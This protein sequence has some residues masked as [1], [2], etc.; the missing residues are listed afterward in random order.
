MEKRNQ[1]GARLRA[2]TQVR[3]Y[4]GFGGVGR[5]AHRPCIQNLLLMAMRLGPLPELFPA[6]NR[7]G[8]V[9]PAVRNDYFIMIK[10]TNLISAPAK[11]F[12]AGK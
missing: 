10:K 8:L 9:A 12:A 3:P 2:D 7:P 5:C 6:K 1:G 4:R 11:H